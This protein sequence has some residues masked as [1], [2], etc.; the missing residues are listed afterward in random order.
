MACNTVTGA[1]K[2]KFD[3]LAAEYDAKFAQSTRQL[4]EAVRANIDFIGARNGGRLLDYACGTGFLSRS[5][6]PSISECV[7]IDLSD[8]MVNVYNTKAQ[9][10]GL[11]P[12]GMR[13]YLGNLALPGD[14]RPAAFSG[15]GWFDFD[16]AGVS[17]G[18]HHFEDC[19][20]AAR[21]LVDRL[22]PGGVLFILDFVTGSLADM[23]DAAAHGVVRH[24]F[25]E[26]DM[27][28]IFEAAGAGSD[29]GFKVLGKEVTFH[30][31]NGKNRTR[32]VFLAR[33]SKA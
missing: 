21:R 30:K 19:E 10:E 29:F 1:N 17:V 12:D 8:N 31:P 33:G 23:P 7:G 28:G 25:S 9:N 3:L 11:Y 14:P 16:M 5:M 26:G 15:P 6:M 20:L 18:F 2:A 32:R 4:E 22:R 13:A 24:G 27:K